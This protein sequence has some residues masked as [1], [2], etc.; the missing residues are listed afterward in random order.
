[1]PSPICPKMLY[2]QQ[3]IDPLSSMAHVCLKPELIDTAVLFSPRLAVG[4]GVLL[5]WVVPSPISPPQFT[6]QQLTEPLSS[7]AHV[8]LPPADIA[9]AVLFSP[10]PAVWVGT[11]RSVVV[12]SPIMPSR[13]L[14]QQ[15]T[16]PSS[17]RAHVC[18]YPAD[19]ATAV[20]LSPK[21]AIG[22]G[23]KR[24]VVVLSPIWP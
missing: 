11:C 3:L 2:P 5:S 10:K 14:P 13:F 21:P 15:L 16:V 24:C 17:S 6:P 1:M 22:V 8:C 9:T 7:M 19:I 20:L 18:S 12:L 23:V 4:V